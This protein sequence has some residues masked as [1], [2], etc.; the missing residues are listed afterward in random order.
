MSKDLKIDIFDGGSISSAIEELIWYKRWVTM[1]TKE[2]LYELVLRGENL[3]SAN[4]ASADIKSARAKAELQSSISGIFNR[5]LGTGVLSVGGPSGS[6]GYF[7]V[8]VE[9]GTGVVGARSPHPDLIPGW[10]YDSSGH[11]ESGWYY[12]KEAD[13]QVHWTQGQPSHPFMYQTGKELR[14]EV[15]RIAKEVFRN[16]R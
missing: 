11:G 16:G 4:I 8:F 1:C 15:E 7:A 2:L 14:N 9:F 3:L 5:N 12:Y 10:G 6:T 13:G